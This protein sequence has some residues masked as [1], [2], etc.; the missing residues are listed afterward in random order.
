MNECACVLAA[1]AGLVK[2]CDAVAY[3]PDDDLTYNLNGLLEE[4]KAVS[5]RVEST[6]FHTAA[7]TRWHFARS[8]ARTRGSR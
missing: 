4:A 8:L 5:R 3:Y 7:Y 6:V 2:L 1:S